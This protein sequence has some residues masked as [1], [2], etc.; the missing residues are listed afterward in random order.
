MEK[1]RLRNMFYSVAYKY[2]LNLIEVFFTEALLTI[3]DF[4]D[5]IYRFFEYIESVIKEGRIDIMIFFLDKGMNPN[6]KFT[7]TILSLACYHGKIDIVTLLVDRKAD[8]NQGNCDEDTPIFFAMCSSDVRIID[9]LITNGANMYHRNDEGEN[10]WGPSSRYV[11]EGNDLGDNFQR[12]VDYRVPVDEE[13][14]LHVK[15][16][17][18]QSPKLQSLLKMMQEVVDIQGFS[19]CETCDEEEKEEEDNC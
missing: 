17:V 12:L 6:M 15:N 18:P 8:V 10:V 4:T 11:C 5:D 2:R 3:Q 1:D 14:Y 7:D 9:C 16:E 13:I 19:K